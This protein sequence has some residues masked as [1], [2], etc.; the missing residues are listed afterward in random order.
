M[1]DAT[2]ATGSSR[3]DILE[4]CVTGL[5]SETLRAAHQSGKDGQH[6]ILNRPTPQGMRFLR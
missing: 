5:R 6:V 3:S 4:L 2:T 1:N